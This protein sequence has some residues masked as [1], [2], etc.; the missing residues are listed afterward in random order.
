[1]TWWDYKSIYIIDVIFIVYYSFHNSFFLDQQILKYS[2]NN[3]INNLVNESVRVSS[4]RVCNVG[5][6]KCFEI[7]AVL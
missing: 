6:E 2:T 3:W 4:C 1:M 7:V 5:I